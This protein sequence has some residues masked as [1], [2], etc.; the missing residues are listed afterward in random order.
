M[1]NFVL[2]SADEARDQKIFS[3]SIM[4]SKNID[5]L[6]LIKFIQEYDPE[7]LE[8]FYSSRSNLPEAKSPVS[9][10]S[11]V[12]SLKPDSV[13]TQCV[14][15]K[16]TIQTDGSSTLPKNPSSQVLSVVIR[17][18]PVEL[19]EQIVLKELKSNFLPVK[20]AHRMYRAS[21][22][23][24]FDCV[25]V[26]LDFS[27]EGNKIFNVKT[28]CYLSVAI[29][30][31]RYPKKCSRCN[32]YGHREQVCYPERVIKFRRRKQSRSGHVPSALLPPSLA[33][34]TGD[35]NIK[36][37]S[38]TLATFN[39]DGLLKQMNLVRDFVVRNDVDV[40]LVQ[41]SFLKPNICDPVIENFS[42]VRNDRVNINGGT[43]IYFKQFLDCVPLEPPPLLNIE[44]SICRLEM[45]GHEA[46]VIASVYL[47][48]N[49]TILESDVNSLLSLG[50]SVILAG[51]LNSKHTR[52]NSKCINA[53]GKTL[54]RLLD[55]QVFDMRIAAPEEP[56]RYPQNDREPKNPDV[57]DIAVL[58]NVTLLHSVE[59]HA[60]LHS[61]HRPVLL[62]LQ[63]P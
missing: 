42:V 24:P 18:F 48:P 3:N 63:T 59:V 50:K 2:C 22:S 37:R 14:N 13:P 27:C 9:P 31:A 49:K 12:E 62:K 61:D 57:L 38:L 19:S 35:S 23:T 25:L 58:K 41:E 36:P 29:E 1:P 47:S 60:G 34:V 20:S 28:V 10:P 54:S 26:F 32:L 8:K 15:N 17:S 7:L 39:A 44:A 51:D 21:T 33:S 6:R 4:D 16:D 53:R 52:W 56:T 40:L 55:K 5:Y 45:T 46:I 30:L 43:L 11:T